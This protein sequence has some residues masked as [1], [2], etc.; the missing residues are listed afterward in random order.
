VLSGDLDRNDRTDKNGVVTDTVG[1]LGRNAYHVV[2]ADG[3]G[4]AT[5]LDGLT[6]TAGLADGTDEQIHGG[7][8]YVCSSNLVLQNVSFSGNHAD[9]HGG[10]MSVKSW[11]QVFLSQVTLSGGQAAR[12]GGISSQDSSLQLTNVTFNDN[13]ASSGQ[14]LGGG[15][16]IQWGVAV[17]EDVTFS[18]NRADHYGGGIYSYGS[19]H[20]TNVTFSSN[21]ADRGGGMTCMGSGGSPV[22]NNVAFISNQA[23]AE[24]GGLYSNRVDVNLVNVTFTDNEAQQPSGAR[25]RHG[26]PQ[27]YPRAD[28]RHVCGQSRFSPR[29]RDAQLPGQPSSS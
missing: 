29:R 23:K 7:G 11:S 9:S 17:L 13:H 24:G 27:R 8:M 4:D 6:V 10:A 18:G 22:L 5:V 15:M 16:Y 1:I 14:R 26:H 12:G 21:Q 25:G 3:V 28:E 19:H 2:V 20:L